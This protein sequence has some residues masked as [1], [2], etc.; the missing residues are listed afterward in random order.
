M[1]EHEGDRHLVV[2]LP[3]TVAGLDPATGESLWDVPIEPA[4][5]MSIVLPQKEDDIV[6]ATGHGGV[7]VAFRLPASR[8]EQA[9]ILWRGTPKTSVACANSTPTI[10]GGVIYG[11]DSKS[12][13]LI[14]ASLVDG[15]RLWSTLKPTLGEGARGFHGTAFLVRQ[16]ETDRYW[17]ASETGDL[18]LARLTP[19]GYDELGRAP[20]LEPTGETF[21]RAVWWSHPAFA[22]GRVYARNDEEIVCVDL[23]A[24]APGH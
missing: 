8:G 2:Y 9:E 11:C 14:A 17:L 10:R 5:E 22:N 1:I 12:S 16:G 24:A 6:F 7:S 4:Y 21:G 19:E 13:E 18:I 20:L 3:T 23:S 15:Q